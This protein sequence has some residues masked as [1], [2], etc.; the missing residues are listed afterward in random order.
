MKKII[1]LFIIL[2][3]VLM[4]FQSV[5]AAKTKGSICHEFSKYRVAEDI[6]FVIN[7]PVTINDE[8]SIPEKST[9]NAKFMMYRNERRWHRSGFFVC[10]LMNYTNGENGE[11]VDVSDKDIYFMA[12][13]YEQLDKKEAAILTTEIIVT[14]AASIVGSCFI[15]FAPVD[16]AYFFTK[17]AIQREKH[18]NWFKA[19]VFN[20]YDNSIFWFWLKGRPIELEEGDGIK[21]KTLKKKKAVKLEQKMQKAIEKQNK[22]DEK[23]NLKEQK[24]LDKYEAKCAKKKEKQ[25]KKIANDQIKNNKRQAKILAKQLKK[26]QKKLEKQQKEDSNL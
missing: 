6:S 23:A 24:K 25:D 15:I 5:E 1:T 21:V 19:G 12:K 2:A 8:I 7:E 26:E 17:G 3:F 20:A 9:L 14:Q 13:K 4:P 10:R 22:K 18:H 11:I 16:I